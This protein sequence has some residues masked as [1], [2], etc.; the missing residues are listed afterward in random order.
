MGWSI[1]NWPGETDFVKLTESIRV[2]HDERKGQ[3]VALVRGVEETGVLLMVV[4]G[5]GLHNA[6]DL[7]RLF[8]EEKLEQKLAE[9]NVD[10]HVPKAEVGDVQPKGFYIEGIRAGT[11]RLAGQLPD[12]DYVE[13]RRWRRT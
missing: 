8:G 10:R 1:R 4:L 6:I 2:Q 12:R 11:E 5:K 7:L 9:R 13:Q 3:D